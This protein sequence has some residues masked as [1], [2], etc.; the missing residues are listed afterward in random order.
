M[1][2]V[3]TCCAIASPSRSGSV[4]MKHFLAVLRRALQLGDRLFLA[5]NRHEV[6]REAVLDVD[7]E[8]LLGQVHDVADRRANAIAAAE[9]LADRLRL[10][11]RLDDDERARRPARR[12]RL[13]VGR[14]DRRRARRLCRRASPSPWSLP[15]SSPPPS[16]LAA[17]FFAAAF[18]VAMLSVPSGVGRPR[19]ARRTRRL[20]LGSA[21]RPARCARRSAAVP[22]R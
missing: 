11:R 20:P 8:L 12:L 21:G 14:F 18:F 15:S 4:A 1:I 3:A 16:S 2:C 9:V 10:G 6:R 17:R 19:P 5:G 22:V 7:A 13:V